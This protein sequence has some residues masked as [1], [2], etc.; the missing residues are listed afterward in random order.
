[1]SVRVYGLCLSLCV[2]D[3]CVCLWLHVRVSVCVSVRAWYLHHSDSKSSPSCSSDAK[4][5]VLMNH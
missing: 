5:V 2:Y 1:M 4:A 3:L